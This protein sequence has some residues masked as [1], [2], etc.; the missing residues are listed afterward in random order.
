M[1][2]RD[3]YIA[4]ISELKSLSPIISDEQRKGLLRR[5]VQQYDINVDEAVDIL[6]ASGITTGEQ[7]DYFQVL[8][9]SISE[10]DN[11]SETDIAFRIES[12]HRLLYSESLKAGGR[13]RADGRTEAQWRTLLNEARDVLIDTESRQLYI[14]SLQNIDTTRIEI[15]LEEA[16]QSPELTLAI[17]TEH[18]EISTP[19]EKDGMI[20]IP[21]GD[22]QM[23]SNE[24]L[25][26]NDEKPVHTVYL[27][28]FY[29]DK[30]PVTNAQ[31]KEFVEVNPEWG[32]PAKWFEQRESD[33]LNIHKM[34]HDGEY[35]KHWKTR[36][37]PNGEDDHPVTWVSWYAAMAYA[38]WIGKRLPTEAEWE[39]AARGGLTGEKY[40]WGNTIDS[41]YVNYDAYVGKTTS[42]GK[43][44]ANGYGL[45]DV[46]GNVYEW[47]LDKWDKN[48]YRYSPQNNPISGESIIGTVNNFTGIRSSRILRGGSCVSRPQNVRV[49]YRSRNTPKFTCFSIGF[50][51]VMPADS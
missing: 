24:I 14:A 2:K 31:Y 20:L 1:S 13:P 32:K 45:Y 33:N 36:D 39:K 3:E 7:V 51:C 17:P 48:F 46:V 25:A 26:H 6:E 29:I 40:P 15:D 47:C 34:Y 27:D 42:I 9:L 35:L 18:N 10:F 30:Y 41:S 50:R 38:N 21:S 23:G 44:P 12:A 11:R 28:A 19:T 22:F 37:Y 16:E 8:G 43:Y 49:A 4:F 5:A